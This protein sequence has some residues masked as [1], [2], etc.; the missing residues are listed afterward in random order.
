MNHVNL[1]EVWDFSIAID[2]ISP[3]MAPKTIPATT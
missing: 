1:L 3:T 2:A